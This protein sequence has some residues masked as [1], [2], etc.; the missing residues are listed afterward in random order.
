MATTKT[1]HLRHKQSEGLAFG[2]NNE[3]QFG[4]RGGF[5]P[6][7]IIVEED[8]PLLELLIELE[9]DNL[10]VVPEDDGP[11]KV[12]VSPLD[13]DKEYKTRAGLV[14][15]MRKAAKDGNAIADLWLRDNIADDD[16]DKDGADDSDGA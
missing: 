14:G 4:V 12:Y 5:A 10:E 11:V 2:P 7:E 6:G 3:L 9:G 16:P 8:H 1:V 15:A 13:P